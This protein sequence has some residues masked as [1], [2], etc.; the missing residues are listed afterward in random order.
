MRHKKRRQLL[1]NIRLIQEKKEISK[2]SKRASYV[3]L[4]QRKKVPKS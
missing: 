1:N 3:T 2:N 4:D